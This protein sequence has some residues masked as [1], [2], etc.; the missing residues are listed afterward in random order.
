MQ[1]P[2]TTTDNDLLSKITTFINETGIACRAGKIPGSTF[3][4]GVMIQNGCIIYDA[5]QL[6]HP[7]DLL[8]EAGHLAMLL[9]EHRAQ[10]N[11]ADNISGDL[12][13]GAAEMGAIAW[14]WAA[15][16]HLGIA[17]ELLSHAEGYKG[18][19]E[20]MINNF[21][22]GRYFG[23]PILQWPG[24]TMDPDPRLLAKDNAYPKMIRWLRQG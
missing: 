19:S 24:M 13:A 5:M 4:P 15:K 7:G 23:V 3:L 10:A 8:H 12:D 14:S 16:E 20:N 22:S 17:P 6:K 9:A 11:G 18:D 1:L 2:E 21:N